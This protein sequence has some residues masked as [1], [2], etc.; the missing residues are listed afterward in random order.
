MRVAWCDL[1]P[2]SSTAET[3]EHWLEIAREF[4][5]K[6]ALLTYGD[7]NALD[8]CDS[9]PWYNHTTI[10]HAF[11]KYGVVY[12]M[13][14]K[15]TQSVA[16]IP[17]RDVTF[18][19]RR[20]R[21]E[22]ELGHDVAPLE[23][24]SIEKMLMI[25]IPSG[26][27]SARAQMCDTFRSAN[28]EAFWHGKEIFEE[29]HARLIRYAH[30]MEIPLESLNLLDW[31]ALIVRAKQHDE[32]YLKARA[33][34]QSLLQGCTRSYD[35]EEPCRWC[36]YLHCCMKNYVDPLDLRP[37]LYCHHC[38]FD[39][40][41]LDCI[42]C[43]EED[44]C[45]QCGCLLSQTD[46]SNRRHK[47]C[48][49][50]H[51]R[52]RVMDTRPASNQSSYTFAGHGFELQG[53]QDS[54]NAQVCKSS[55]ARGTPLFR[56]GEHTPN[57]Q[58]QSKHGLARHGN[59]R[60]ANTTEEMVISND[61]MGDNMEQTVSQTATFMDSDVGDVITFRET[62]N[63]LMN[64]DIDE[65]QL[66]DF[67]K[68]PTLIKSFTWSESGFGETDFDPWSL[69]L[70]N[71]NI[72]Y[73]LNNFAYFRGNLKVKIL[74]N[75]SPFY[76]G[77]L[78]FA[79]TPLQDTIM[80]LYSTTNKLIPISQQPGLWLY[81]QANAGG[82]MTLPFIW[83]R[84]Y[85]QLTSAADVA[86]LGRFKAIQYT[87]L[88]S[89]NGATSNGC[90]I[91]IYAW[92]ED[93]TVTGPTVGLALQ[94]GMDEYGNG[95]VSAMASATASWANYFTRIPIIGRF[96]KATSIGASAVSQI[97]TLFG[98]TNVPVI[99]DVRPIKNLPFHDL[100]SAHLSEPTSKMTLDPKGELSV[101]P[102][103]IGVE[104]DDELAITSL[105]TRESYLTS[106]LWETTNSVGDLKFAAQVHP[107]M[108]DY[109]TST[110]NT[111]TMANTP[112]GMV[113]SL[114][115][116]W[117]GDIIYRFKVICTKYHKGRLR[118][119]WDPVASLN[120]PND[121]TNIAMTKIIDLSESDEIEFRVPYMQARQWSNSVSLPTRLWSTSAMVTPTAN[122]Y[123]GTI[124][125]RVLT[126]L[127]APVDVAPVS[128]FVFVRGAENIEFAN[129]ADL[130]TTMTNFPMQG[131]EAAF[132]TTPEK[133][134]YLV[135]WGEAVPT[136]RLLLRRS[137]IYDQQ[138]VTAVA[139]DT[140]GYG[141]L[142]QSRFPSSPGYD[143]FGRFAARGVETPGTTYSYTYSAMTPLAAIAPAF[144]AN[145]GS[146]RWHY[147]VDSGGI[148]V[149]TEFSATRVVK[150][151]GPKRLTYVGLISGAISPSQ[152]A[153]DLMYFL[154][155]AFGA[156]GTAVTNC[157][158]QTGLSV[159][160]PM[161]VPVKFLSNHPA[162]W[163]DGNSNE[164]SVEDKYYIRFGIRPGALNASSTDSLKLTRWVSI[165]TDFNLHFFLRCPMTIIQSQMGR[166]PV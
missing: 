63:Q 119:T 92:C 140:Y 163:I 31:D 131:G 136:L 123:N 62:H 14:D 132:E 112:M 74:M 47:C 60:P 105:C 55:S 108:A 53:K 29:W 120:V 71:T 38:R 90:T 146:I 96:A 39:D 154:D 145:R 162:N 75:A 19:K 143:P 138:C 1:H 161:M 42:N 158:T 152:K 30:L 159:E 70:N 127:S 3:F 89:A 77:A 73:K 95:P 69:F 147:N 5:K 27:I 6:V 164:G 46:I 34:R 81:P 118:I 4:K 104:A 24:S 67:L 15:E 58:N 155:P 32:A 86:K 102:R 160:M 20:W 122:V 157:I 57:F 125:V 49:C 45:I 84:N 114:F 37:C 101:D 72:K 134:Q 40:P 116:H 65:V 137:Q 11:E 52:D 82:E 98:W 26:I 10:S 135:N 85:V 78:F 50:L 139:A 44:T 128:I 156:S 126:N 121:T 64:D 129:P 54:M 150:P 41:D 100:A 142:V 79:Y 144:V 22:P 25:H 7:D 59:K 141:E 16:Y 18:L 111:Y 61:H 66:G 103:I 9:C 48:D 99:E 106:S 110:A 21:F 133:E 115:R 93:S 35:V 8:V 17:F 117:R 166:T 148:P 28:D 76:Y 153:Y 51:P 36:G 109:V 88:A 130:S 91:Q 97:A 43:G 56:G 33:A 113:G 13:A 87:P 165:G 94:G 68:R 12:T 107:Q 80:P 151:V 23:M 83:D 149:L 2:R 124:T